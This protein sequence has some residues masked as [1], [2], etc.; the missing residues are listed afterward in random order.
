VPDELIK[1]VVTH[2]PFIPPPGDEHAGI[3]LV[4]RARKALDVIDRCGVDLLL[5]GHVHHGYTGDVR[6]HYPSARRSIVVAQAGTAISHRVRHEPNAYNLIG[7]SRDRIDVVV[8]RWMGERFEETGAVRYHRDGDAWT[9]EKV[10]Y[11]PA[12]GPR[13]PADDTTR[14]A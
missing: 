2:H 13:A 4:G 3:A 10:R 12:E 11:D 14:G 5:A 8:R 6:T 1:I 9:L 7:V